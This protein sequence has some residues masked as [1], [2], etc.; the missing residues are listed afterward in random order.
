MTKTGKNVFGE[1]KHSYIRVTVVAQWA[2]NVPQGQGG[3]KWF[4]FGV[5]PL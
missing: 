1:S 2:N 4:N 5:K 3:G